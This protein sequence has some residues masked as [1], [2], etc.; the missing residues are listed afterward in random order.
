MKNRQKISV[1]LV[2]VLLLAAVPLTSYATT[3]QEKLN[4][5]E[6]EKKDTEEK[7][8][9][10]Q[11]DIDGL[12]QEQNT[13]KGELSN[14]NNQ[15]SEVSTNLSDLE[16]D[17]STKEL[18]IEVTEQA[19]AEAMQIEEE[20][21][22]AMKK[23]IQFMY[24]RRDFMLM[25]ML[26]EAGSFGDFLNFNDYIEKLSEYDKKMLDE[27]QATI[28]TIEE[29]EARLREEKAE[30]ENLK[31]Q[32]EAEKSR[33]A[34]LVSTTSN[35]IA[36]YSNQISDAEAEA[37]AYEQ[38]IKEQEEN[39]EYL[40]KKLA[41]E[42]AMSQLAA[43]SARRNISE[44]TFADGD[45]YLLANL[46]YCEAGGE[47]YEGQVAVGAVV[48]NRVLSS[49]YPDTVVGV[50]YQNKQFSPVASGRLAL[51]LAEGRATESC[52]RAAD[53]A[54]AGVTNVGNCVYFRTPIEG[55]TGIR[56]GGHI[57]Y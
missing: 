13:L 17:I 44:V 33:V 46:I 32:A 2:I 51:A 11:E 19:L 35:N 37:L 57:F 14:L 49:V 1:I 52:Y 21:Y 9:D 39:I 34:G 30:L 56:I 38:Q 28:V 55:L 24:E 42:I 12:K 6:Q 40:K 41:E 47:P 16:E 23:R 26:L 4:Q 48:I 5:A 27:Y 36:A 29:E 20:Q 15:L 50:I 25:E 7:L 8:E 53:E 54:M 3:T 22:T 43:N 45:R 10:K 18:E 31:A